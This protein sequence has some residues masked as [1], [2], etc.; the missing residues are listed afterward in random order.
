MKK[1]NHEEH[2]EHEVQNV[3]FVPIVTFVV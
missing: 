3:I 2:E 1:L